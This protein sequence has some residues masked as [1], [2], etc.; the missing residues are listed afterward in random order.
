MFAANGKTDALFDT[1]QIKD[2]SAVYPFDIVITAYAVQ[3]E[4]VADLDAAKVALDNLMNPQ[5]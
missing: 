3:A 4:G 1:V 5:A 2:V